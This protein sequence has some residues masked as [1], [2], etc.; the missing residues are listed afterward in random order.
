MRTRWIGLVAVLIW[1]GTA[2][3]GGPVLINELALLVALGCGA[4]LAYRWLR[5]RFA[6]RGDSHRDPGAE[7]EQVGDEGAAVTPGD[8]P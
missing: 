8:L 2:I 1:V 3:I 6:G 5:G 4:I 7:P